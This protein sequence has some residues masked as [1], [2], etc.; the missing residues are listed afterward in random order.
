MLVGL[1]C[2]NAREPDWAD[3]DHSAGEA[4]AGTNCVDLVRVFRCMRFALRGIVLLLVVL[5]Q[6]A[7]AGGPRY[8]A[9]VGPRQRYTLHARIKI[10][11]TPTRAI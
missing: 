9:G 5:L 11:I 2:R 4:A 3:F 10:A 7:W 8:V 1:Y 6:L